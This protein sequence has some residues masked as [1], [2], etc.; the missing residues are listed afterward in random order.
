M[1]T[2]RCVLDAAEESDR[3]Y[4][5]GGIRVLGAGVSLCNMPKLVD[6]SPQSNL[7]KW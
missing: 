1:E 3:V 5:R 6:L 4:I 7:D 2:S